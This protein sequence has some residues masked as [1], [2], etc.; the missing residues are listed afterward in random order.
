MSNDTNNCEEVYPGESL[1][2]AAKALC[3]AK[4]KAAEATIGLYYSSPQGVA[5]HPEVIE[6]IIKLAK[7]GSGALDAYNFLED[8]W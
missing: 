8:R 6:E 4:V 1:M 3:Q 7:E 5:G 2:E